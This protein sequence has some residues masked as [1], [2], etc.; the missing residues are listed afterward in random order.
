MEGF[1]SGEFYSIL[2]KQSRDVT[3]AISRQKDQVRGIRT[4]QIMR[5]SQL[6]VIIKWTEEWLSAPYWWDRDQ[7]RQTSPTAWKGSSSRM[8]QDTAS[9]I[10][11]S[12][13]A[14]FR[15]NS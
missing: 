15:L 14:K 7:G 5:V 4:I 11:S 12:S 9:M 6:S 3:A 2:A 1:T 8:P 10:N 13:A